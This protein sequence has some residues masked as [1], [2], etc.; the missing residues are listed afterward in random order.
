M[1]KLEKILAHSPIPV[2]GE[3]AM[4][5]SQLKELGNVELT[6]ELK[7]KVFMNTYDKRTMVYSTWIAAV[8]IPSIFIYNYLKK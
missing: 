6:E 5:N 4:Y 7:L 2:I 3:I 8:I 1:E